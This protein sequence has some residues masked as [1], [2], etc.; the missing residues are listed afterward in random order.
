MAGRGLTPLREIPMALGPQAMER[1]LYRGG[2]R[3]LRVVIARLLHFVRPILE[4][5]EI[6][7]QMAFVEIDYLHCG[8]PLIGQMRSWAMTANVWRNHAAVF[9]ATND[10]FSCGKNCGANTTVFPT[11]L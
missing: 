8:R 3:R 7:R 5:V 9:A 4:A 6:E 2:T 1:T 11:Q 10:Q